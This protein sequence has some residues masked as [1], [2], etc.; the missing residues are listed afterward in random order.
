VSSN[1]IETTSFCR[2]CAGLCALRLT[3]EDGRIVA[4]R[5]DKSNPLTQ[6]YACIKGLTAH[7]AQYSPDRI[8]H[9]LK[10]RADGR[11]E[12]I[13]LEQALDEIA[14][15]VQSIIA[16]DGA[17]AVAGFRGTMNYS[18]ATANFMLPA[19]LQ[20]LGSSSFFSTMTVDQSAKWITLG[21]LGGWGAGR[22]AFD[23]ADVLMFVGTNPLVSLS[24]FNFFLQHPVKAMHGFKARGGK[25]IVIDPRQTET[26]RHADIFLQPYPGEDVTVIAGLLHLILDSGWHDAQFCTQWVKELERLRT[27]VATF[28]PAY[29]AQRAGIDAGDLTAAASLFAHECRRG[30]A[31]SGTG[32]NMAAH[33]NLAEH[34]IEC[35]NVVCGRYARAGDR[36][37]NPGVLGS[38]YARRAQVIAPSRSWERGPQSRLGYGMIYGERMSGVLAEEITTPGPGRLRALFV[39]A[40]NLVNAIPDQSKITAALKDLDLLV[41]IDPF[42]TNTARLS[43]YVLPPRLMFERSDVP[44]RDYE[45][46]TVFRP[47]SAYAR[48][49][50]EPPAD[51]EVADDWYLF[52]SIARRL[53][54]TIAF[55]GVR[56]DMS[57]S[58]TTDELLRILTRNGALPF[59]QLQA[60]GSGGFVDVPPQFV[61]EAAPG[62]DGRFDVMPDDVFREL[63]AV[64][65][66]TRPSGFSHRL[67]VRRLREVQNTMYHQL[68]S[69]RRRMP[70]NSV[71]MH[72]L[73]MAELGL[74]A[75]EDVRIE[76]A[77]GAIVTCVEGDESMRRGV[78]SVAHGWGALPD[79]QADYR[80]SGVSTNLLIS[81]S[82][83]LDPINAMPVMT[84]IP[85]RIS[86]VR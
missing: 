48:P 81:T 52:W 1:T 42:M 71:Y 43:H 44:S 86:A 68:P 36:V 29:V 74:L 84:G 72:P 16:R 73:D 35:L 32:P 27:A 75:G 85:V 9:P 51:A 10:R 20:A 56:L 79:E 38:R 46:F 53:G 77:H 4:A 5:G 47:Y 15:R 21:R 59:E 7:E 37:P 39:D 67:A 12:R 23:V 58:P 33:S 3:L 18:N 45:S 41:T 70:F 55:D 64:R 34:L 62:A 31:A 6:G 24:T 57:T 65:V 66:E 28:T 11:F 26:A 49:V 25:V 63:A 60:L 61:E 78:V 17:D 2:I 40:G 76:S 13:G 50:V 19:F 80:T 69:V 22:D 82:T 54:K 83:G 30:S 14:E 8:L